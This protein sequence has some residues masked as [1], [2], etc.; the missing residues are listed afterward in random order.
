MVKYSM[1]VSA[2]SI[3]CRRLGNGISYRGI[4]GYFQSV[5]ISQ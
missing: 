2:N 3:T 4:R 5:C 1:P